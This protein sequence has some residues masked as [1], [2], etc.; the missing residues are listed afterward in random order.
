MEAASVASC[1]ALMTGQ[2]RK[3]KLAGVTSVEKAAANAAFEVGPTP[4]VITARRVAAVAAI[5]SILSIV[6]EMRPKYERLANAGAWLPSRT[7]RDSTTRSRVW[8][9]LNLLSPAQV[10]PAGGVVPTIVQLWR[11][12]P[13]FGLGAAAA[14]LY[15]L[16]DPSKPSIVG[17]NVARNIDFVVD[18]SEC[19]AG[20]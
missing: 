9:G 12:R 6:I 4:R 1:N 8:N 3:T 15:A 10:K 19:E 17:S 7:A 2:I 11:A 13:R 18:L 14:M 20:E 16:A 5:G